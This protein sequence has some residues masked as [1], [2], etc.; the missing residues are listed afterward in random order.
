MR[1]YIQ[2]GR[3]TVG[4]LDQSEISDFLEAHGGRLV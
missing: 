4:P 3:F 1:N 2:L